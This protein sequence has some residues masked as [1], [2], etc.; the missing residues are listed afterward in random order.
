MRQYRNGKAERRK[1]A[2]IKNG[3]P[4]ND[5]FRQVKSFIPKH[6]V[7]KL[8]IISK[9]D[10]VPMSRLVAIAVHNHIDQDVPFVLNLEIPHGIPYNKGEFADEARAVYQFLIKTDSGMGLDSIVLCSEQMGLNSLGVL[11]G[12]R[13]LLETGLIEEYYPVR[14]KFKYPSNARF[15]R[16]KSGA[17]R[18]VTRSKFKNLEGGIDG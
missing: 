7:D 4:E 6:L 18:E 5:P 3:P 12:V 14:A 16:V 17:S 9:R 11:V 13:E 10:G 8:E 2:A 1:Q 15:L